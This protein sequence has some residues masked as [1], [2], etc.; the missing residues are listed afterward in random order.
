MGQPEQVSQNCSGHALCCVVPKSTF[1]SILAAFWRNAHYQR[2]P[3]PQTPVLNRIGNLSA[4]LKFVPDDDFFQAV[5]RKVRPLNC[6]IRRSSI[7][8]IKDDV[9]A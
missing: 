5:Q 1:G 3:K 2:P 6:K 4:C 8:Q 7:V 9:F